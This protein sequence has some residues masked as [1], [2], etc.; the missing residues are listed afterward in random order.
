MRFAVFSLPSP[1]SVDAGIAAAWNV[2]VPELRRGAL[3]ERE[4]RRDQNAAPAG[5]WT[6]TRRRARN[7]RN[8]GTHIV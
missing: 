4:E 8:F 7:Y 1:A 6:Q 2:R 3:R 5:R